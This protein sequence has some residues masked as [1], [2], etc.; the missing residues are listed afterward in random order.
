MHDCN[1]IC[2]RVGDVNVSVNT[3]WVP[4]GDSSVRICACVPVPMLPT[5]AS[6]PSIAA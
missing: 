6:H 3:A 5:K 1:T 2:A 4:S